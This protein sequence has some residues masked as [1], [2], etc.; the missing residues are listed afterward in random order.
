MTLPHSFLKLPSIFTSLPSTSKS[1]K[2]SLFI[3]AKQGDNKAFEELIY[4][5]ID[6]L[7]GK[8]FKNVR[9]RET[10]ED[11]LQNC[12]MKIYMN[13][14]TLKYEGAFESWAFQICS[15]E[16]YHYFRSTY[17][18]YLLIHSPT[19]L[20]PSLNLIP[21]DRLYVSSSDQTPEERLIKKS[22][23]HLVQQEIRVLPPPQKEVL[24]LWIQ[25]HTLIELTEILELSLPTV[26]SRLRRARILLKTQLKQKYGSDFLKTRH[27]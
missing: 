6:R 8:I 27:Q 10:A 24:L 5:L 21:Q 2:D 17:R 1:S 25:G 4:P 7:Y 26:K 13:L 14:K 3:R 16:I 9:H 19:P 22:I 20:N 18:R 15:N 11:L 12:L 23:V